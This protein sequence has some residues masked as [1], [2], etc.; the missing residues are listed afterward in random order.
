MER[1]DRSHLERAESLFITNSLIGV[2][3]VHRINNRRLKVD[4][5]LLEEM[6]TILSRWEAPLRG[7]E[8]K[9]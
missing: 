6:R 5:D 7:E 2:V 4:S 9:I 8:D 3:P 1:L